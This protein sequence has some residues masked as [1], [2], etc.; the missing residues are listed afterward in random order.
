MS[1]LLDSFWRAVAYCLRP[2]VLILSLLPLL[3]MVLL[4]GALGY[5]FWEAAVDQVLA[6]SQTST[7]MG[8]VSGW[9]DSLGLG[10]LKAVVAPLIVIF[11]STPVIVASSVLVVAVLMMPTLVTLVERRRF[12]AL[13]RRR[14]SSWLGSFV[15]SLGSLAMAAVAML[16]SVPL[17]LVPPLILIVP[18]LIWGWLTY[19]VMAFDAL[20]DHASR[21]ERRELFRRHR[22]SFLV[23]GLL[24][25]Y[26]SAAPSLLWASGAVF[27]AAFVI[28]VPIVIWVYTVV[29]A[30]SSLW[31]AHFC[32][33]ALNALRT[34]A[35]RDG[36]DAGGASDAID[37]PSTTVLHHEPHA[38]PPVSAP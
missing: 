32:L 7:L 33:A 28:L 5:F 30:F 16:V 20:A 36:K 27:A 35:A 31:F 38:L 3:L 18:P 22:A 4:F 8:T 15:W 14:G 1:L 2:Q 29:F 10:G 6:V 17:W 21:N 11:L 19:R 12:P 9:F 26:M 23:M 13:Q 37:V 24:S 34:E 25:G